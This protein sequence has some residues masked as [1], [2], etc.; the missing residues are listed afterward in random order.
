MTLFDVIP[1]LFPGNYG[2]RAR[3]YWRHVLTR[4]V[5]R[6]RRIV[7]LS[8]QSRADIELHLGVE[9]DRIAGSG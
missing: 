9:R 3:L 6:A 2:R 8:E 4:T 5:R 7:T 1:I